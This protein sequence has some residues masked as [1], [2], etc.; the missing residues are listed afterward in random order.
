MEKKFYVI[1]PYQPLIV[2]KENILQKIGKIFNL[3]AK[4]T[5]IVD[6]EIHHKELIHRTEVVATG[7]G[8]VG[9]RAVQLNTLEL[10]ELYYSSYNP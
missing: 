2:K 10:S 8:S 3:G 5:E 4:K 6:F 1:V 9:L 7:L